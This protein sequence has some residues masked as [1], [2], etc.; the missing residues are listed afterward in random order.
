M[1]NSSDLYYEHILAKTARRE[2][3]EKNIKLK[4]LKRLARRVRTGKP[5][6]HFSVME[7]I[8]APLSPTTGFGEGAFE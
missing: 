1:K 4:M 6:Q 3:R 7:S 8:K 2:K 5:Y